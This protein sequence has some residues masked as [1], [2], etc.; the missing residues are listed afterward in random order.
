MDLGFGLPVSGAW[1]TPQNQL[2][3]ATRADELGFAGVWSF[4]R[5]LYPA[6][7]TAP[8]W[9]EVYRSVLDP[10]LSLAHVAAS[11]R[12]VRLGVA[13]LNAPFYAPPVLAKQVTTLDVLSSGRAV[14]G[15][16]LGWA[17]EEYAAAGVPMRDRGRRLEEYVRVLDAVWSGDATGFDGEFY[18]L[19]PAR[20]DPLPVQ[21]PRPPLLLGA[22]AEPALRRAGRIAD[23]WVSSSRAP[24]ARIGEMVRTVRQAAEEAGRDPDALRLVCRGAV[25]LRDERRG[26]RA[27]LEG[28]A[29]QIGDDLAHLASQGITET[30]L[31]LN[32]DPQ[33]G[34]PDADPARAMDT[35]HALLEAFG[36]ALPGS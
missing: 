1:A 33:V 28:S 12:R 14:V 20:Q 32:F 21:R 6:E 26:E 7:A 19:P 17:P 9:G 16:G 34:S 35:A 25:R 15:L 10:M 3:V 30:F 13:V 22:T 8:P 36:P 2:E 29:A 24:L 4:F 11:T 27:M 23:G 5:M 31:D 18:T